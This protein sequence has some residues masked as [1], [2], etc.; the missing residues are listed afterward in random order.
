MNR[1]QRY[2]MRCA[3]LRTLASNSPAL[4]LFAIFAL[5]AVLFVA[6]SLISRRQHKRAAAVPTA[7][8]W[9][10]ALVAGDETPTPELRLDMIERLALVGAPWSV[11][12]L[13]AA[14]SEERD[15]LLRDAAE[16]ALLV[17]SSR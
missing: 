5:G 1:S 13:N 7:V 11:D 4:A 14:M 9:T 12:A 15:P 17:I 6:G 3:A 16:R 8:T 10:H 2:W